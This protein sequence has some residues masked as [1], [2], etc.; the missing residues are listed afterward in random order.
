VA[1]KVAA[2]GDVLKTTHVA[3]LLRSEDAPVW[4][5]GSRLMAPLLAKVDKARGLLDAAAATDAG[6][7]DNG[8]N[9]N[10]DNNN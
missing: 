9:T 2:F 3:E 10:N 5:P 4:T 1:D 8:D 6:N 7:G